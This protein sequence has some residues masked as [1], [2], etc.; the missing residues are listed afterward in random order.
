MDRCVILIL[1]IVGTGWVAGDNIEP[2]KGTEKNSK[3]G[4]TVKLSC[5]Y[6]T[7]AVNVVLYWTKDGVI[8]QKAGSSSVFECETAETHCNTDL[9]LRAQTTLI[10]N[11]EKHLF[12]ILILTSGVM[13]ADQIRPNKD[14]YVITEEETVALSCTYDTSSS[15]AYLYWYRHAKQAQESNVDSRFT[16]KVTKDKENH[17]DLILSSAAVS[18]SAL[19]YCALQPTFQRL[20][21]NGKAKDGIITQK[22]GSSSVFECETAE[23][24]SNTDL[25]LRAQTTLIHNMEKHLLLILILTSGVMT[26]DQ[27]RPNKD[28]YVIKEE[29]TLALSCTYDTSGSLVYLYW[30]RQYPN[31]EPQYL[32]FRPARSATTSG[33]SADPRF[34]SAT[35]QTSTELTITGVTVSD[36]ALYYCALRVGAQ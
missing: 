33:S 29:E 16:A 26:A 4:E 31:G 11:M 6:S 17:A 9:Q 20:S 28:T 8:T 12:L 32:I 23:T 13:T 21:S 22:A 19:Y 1:F 34:Q 5:S 10:H 3:E 35:S 30:Y 14:T 24:H 15:Y 18:D 27:I 7:N 25:Q 36:S 2:D